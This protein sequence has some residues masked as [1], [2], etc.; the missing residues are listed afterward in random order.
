MVLRRFDF[1]F[2]P[3]FSTEVPWD[4]KTED[5]NHPVGI[6]TGATIHTRKGLHL[7]IKKRQL[8]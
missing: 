5:L 4:G 8:D 7:R 3:D 2:D 1:E 6:R